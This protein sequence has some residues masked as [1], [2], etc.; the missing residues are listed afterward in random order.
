MN[1]LFEIVLKI[2]LIIVPLL[3]AVA[4]FTLAERKLIG[5]I[6]RRRGPNIVGFFGLLQP[7]ADGLKLLLKETVLPSNAN[8]IIFIFAPILTFL[9]SLIGWAVIPFNEGSVLADIN[10]GVL[11]LFGVSS[12]GVYGIITSGWSSNSRYAFLGSLRSAAQMVSYEV[13]IGLII[14]CV[15]LCAGSLNLTQIVLFQKN[16]WFIF[17]L[18]PVFVMFFISALAET[19]RAP[20]DLPEAEAELVAGYNVE[21]SAMGFALF[22]LGEYANILLISSISVCLFL[23][24]WLPLFDFYPF[25]LI[26]GEIWF[27]LKLGFLVFVFI[28]VRAA[29]PRYRYD[30]LMR[31]GWKVLL[32]FSLGWLIGIASLLF[33]FDWLPIV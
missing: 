33:A 24:G 4:Y 11:Y 17:P 29:F 18:F 22:F 3:V 26:P 6:Q 28:W 15:L 20:F 32:P 7:L 10:I 19:N 9:L 13:S 1:N 31:L 27:S 12:L 21:Y 30:Q 2:L 25:T 16:I 14:I 8:I 23:G 5:Y